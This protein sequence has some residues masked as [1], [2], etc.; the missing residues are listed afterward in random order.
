ML[1]LS[2][3]WPD[4]RGSSTF[5]SSSNLSIAPPPPSTPVPVA[6]S[7]PITPLAFDLRKPG[8]HISTLSDNLDVCVR[9][10]MGGVAGARWGGGGECVSGELGS[11]G[12]ETSPQHQE[13]AS[14]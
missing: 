11:D 3:A 14:R 2:A 9:G 10:Y 7:R 6:P 8:L 12:H 5:C 4:Q 13:S 1:T